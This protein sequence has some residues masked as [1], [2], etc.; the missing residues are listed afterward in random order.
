MKLRHAQIL[1]VATLVLTAS[2]ATAQYNT[3]PSQPM[4]QPQPAAPAPAPAAPAP[5]PATPTP[6]PAAPT[7]APTAPESA[8]AGSVNPT[9]TIDGEIQAISLSCSGTVPDTC[10]ATADIVIGAFPAV[11]NGDHGGERL[12]TAGYGPVTRI[13][14]PAGMLV[15]YGNRQVPVTTLRVGDEMRIDYATTTA[16]DLNIAVNTASAGTVVRTG[17]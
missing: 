9:N 7:P 12:I 2:V 13:Y 3:Q 14:V 4:Y 16:S 17:L 5:A 6:A 10:A 11:V 15:A 1:M 8:P